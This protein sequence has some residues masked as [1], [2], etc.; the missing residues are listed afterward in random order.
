MR[1]PAD[2]DQ[3]L[4]ALAGGGHN[5]V[6]TWCFDKDGGI[7]DA[8]LDRLGQ[9]WWTPVATALRPVCTLGNTL[10]DWGG[11]AHFTPA[12]EEF[13]TFPTAQVHLPGPDS[14]GP[15]LPGPERPSARR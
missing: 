15:L 9:A 11:P 14:S 8:T 13:F 5:T 10:S 2:I 6:R 3:R 7:S 1:P 12:G 4:D